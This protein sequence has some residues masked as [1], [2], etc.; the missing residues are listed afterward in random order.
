M[1]G[2]AVEI[3]RWR[4]KT[5]A[6]ARLYKLVHPAPN[7]SNDPNRLDDED[8]FGETI[9]SEYVVVSAAHTYSGPE[10]FI[11][12]ADATGKVTDWS[13]LPG[14]ITG[15]INHEKALRNVGYEVSHEQ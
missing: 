12:P 6:D 7:V 4:S 2:K 14:S 9:E 15:E 10:T 1:T 8:T 5:G 13:E 11:F 3:K